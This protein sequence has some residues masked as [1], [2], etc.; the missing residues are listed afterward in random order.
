MLK[1][2]HRHFRFC[3]FL[4]YNGEQIIEKV[5]PLV[6]MCISRSTAKNG[7]DIFGDDTPST[8]LLEI[9]NFRVGPYL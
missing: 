8:F 7:G 3:E 1:L 9:E 2:D 4:N 5:W 6:K